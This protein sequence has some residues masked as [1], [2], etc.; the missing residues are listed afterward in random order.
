MNI[1]NFTKQP[2]ETL[3]YDVNYSEW[4]T[5]GDNIEEASVGITPDGLTVES[6]FIND[7]KVKIWISGGENGTTYKLT[8]T[9]TTADGRVK[10]DEFRIKVKET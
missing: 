7:P 9:A 1:G 4:I 10:Q 2:I 6:I 3:D 5:T 8:I